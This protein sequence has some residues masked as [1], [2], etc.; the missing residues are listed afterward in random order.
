MMRTVSIDDDLKIW[1]Q[2]YANL[3]WSGMQDDKI[4]DRKGKTRWSHYQTAYHFVWIPKYRRKVLTG[5]VEK[6]LKILIDECVTKYGWRL[7]ALETDIDHVHCFVSAPPRREPLRDSRT[8]KSV[9]F[10]ISS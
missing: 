10:K 9:H 6:D 4:I 7:L 5:S 3:K 2:E 8:S 1:V